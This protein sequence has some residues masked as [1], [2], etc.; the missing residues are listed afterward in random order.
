MATVRYKW[1]RR[2]Y[3][4]IGAIAVAVTG[5]IAYRGETFNAQVVRVVDGDTLHVAGSRGELVLR[6]WGIDA[7][8]TDQTFGVESKTI[9]ETLCLGDTVSVDVVTV[10]KYNRR[11]CR[12]KLPDGR[13]VGNEMIRLGAAWWAHQY[14]SRDE[15]KRQLMIKARQEKIGMWN[16]PPCRPPWEHRKSSSTVYIAPAGPPPSPAG[17]TALVAIPKRGKLDS[18]QPTA[19]LTE[20]MLK[21]DSARS[22]PL[23]AQAT[24]N[25]LDGQFCLVM[26]V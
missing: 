9:L 10:D 18:L 3:V 21:L 15:T 6:V 8:E 4:A 1:G 26:A 22:R 13:D 5:A 14:A 11:V 23:E 17:A 19:Q 24:F 2:G 7:P 12:I 20:C 25:F 16:S